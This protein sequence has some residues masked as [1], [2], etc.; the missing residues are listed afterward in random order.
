MLLPYFSEAK[1][2]EH[3]GMKYNVYS[4]V[5]PDEWLSQDERRKFDLGS[6]ETTFI[7]AKDNTAGNDVTESGEGE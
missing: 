3:I 2:H 5:N 4:A 6:D 1:Q 7:A